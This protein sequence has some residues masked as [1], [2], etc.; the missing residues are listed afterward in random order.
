VLRT[1]LDPAFS[2]D[3]AHAVRLLTEDDVPWIV[4][5]GKRRYSIA[6][7][8]F[9]AEMWFRNIVLK[10]PLM[11]FP[12]RTDHAFTICMIITDAWL[13]GLRF[14]NSL[15]LNSEEGAVW[16]EI[17]LMRAAVEWARKRQCAE[18]RIWSDTEVDLSAVAVRVGA[19][20][21][22]IRHTVKL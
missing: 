11:F 12:A 20:P 6:F 10:S 22:A 4:N 17:A 14:C 5:L 7:D 18:Y 13:P 9:S 2:P 21:T 3:N 16:E 8:A 1:A 15:L 19:Q